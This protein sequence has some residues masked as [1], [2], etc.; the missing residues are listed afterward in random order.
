MVTPSDVKVPDFQHRFVAEL[1]LARSGELAESAARDFLRQHQ[2]ICRRYKPLAELKWRESF[3]G[4]LTDLAAAMAAARPEIFVAQVNWARTAFKA[5]GVPISDLVL[6]LQQLRDT[7]L[8]EV[9]EE[10]TGLVDS[11]FATALTALESAH[12]PPPSWL[13]TNTPHGRLAAT[14][15][16]AILEGD[17]QKAA[18]QL[19]DAAAN[20]FSVRDIY[21]RVLVP[22]QHEL[23]RMWHVGEVTVAEEHFATAVTASVMAR[24]LPM[25]QPKPRDGRVAIAV[26][27]QCNGHEL[28]ARIVADFLELEGWRSIYLGADLPATDLVAGIH[29]FRAS[30]VAISASMPSQLQYVEQTIK[31]IRQ[32]GPPDVKIMI[33]GHAFAEAPDL[34]RIYGADAFAATVDQAPQLADQ[35]VPRP[36]P[37][38]A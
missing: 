19:V 31:L 32:E 17:R 6:G 25:A 23:G 30:L 8:G 28:A 27:V 26:A 14:Y 21:L 15:L 38:P 9:P 12:A 18:S 1:L 11:Y 33:G 7:L 10:D 29:D 4:R 2:D 5:R 13:A 22:V 20:G 3:V 24:L 36:A 16:L 37:R 35:L 34:W